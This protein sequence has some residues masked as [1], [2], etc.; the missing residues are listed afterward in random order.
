MFTGIIQAIGQI[1]SMERGGDAVRVALDAGAMVLDDISIGDSIA[2]SGPCLTVVEVRG[3]TFLVDVSIETLDRTTL[4]NK[5]VG[6]QVNLEKALRLSD[7]LGG[8]LVSGHVDG[9][10]TVLER[11]NVD[12]YVRFDIEA[13]QDLARYIAT[14]GSIAVDGVS[15]TINSVNANRFQLMI[16]PH[17]LTATTLG[18]LQCGHQLNLEI[19][20]IARYLERLARR[21]TAALAEKTLNILTQAGFVD[22]PSRE[23]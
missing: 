14:K 22:P 10:G 18:S 19:D 3:N 13:P 15:L 17:T 11:V 16:I 21:D 12:T 8:H 6:G 23:T 9:V 2:V 20:L 1:V 4:G 5:R 7:R